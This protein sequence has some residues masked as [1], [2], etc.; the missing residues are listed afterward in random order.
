MDDP[1]NIYYDL[2]ITNIK[3]ETT[4]PV[5]IYFNEN[6]Q[7]PMLQNSGDYRLSITRFQVDTQLLPLFIPEIEMNQSDPNK[8]IYSITYK[9]LPPKTDDDDDD[10]QPIIVHQPIYWN[11]QSKNAPIPP[12][13]S[14][15]GNGLQSTVANYYYA[16]SFQ[17]VVLQVFTALQTGF[18]TLQSQTDTLNNV[19]PPIITW[20]TDQSVA[21]IS[22]P[23]QYFNNHSSYEPNLVENPNAIEL[24]FNTP[25][26]S[27]FSSFP[28]LNYGPSATAGMNY[29]IIIDDMTGFN[30][31]LLPSVPQAGQTQQTFT[32][33]FQEYSTIS[34]W[35][36]VSSICFTSNTLPI[37][38]SQLSAPLL[39]NESRQVS[40]GNNANFFQEITDLAT[41]DLCY[42]PN[43]LY[44]PS[45]QYRYISLNSNVPISNIDVQVY[46]KN[47]LGQFIPLLLASGATCTI[48]F[49]FE[50]LQ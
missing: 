20:N 3:S 44:S 9:Y 1:D 45:A 28:S 21:V 31:T 46:W 33:V 40:L 49:L 41:N 48:K 35:T 12:A 25:L 19:S 13:P 30:T 8:T 18:A 7:A 42:K 34:N 16:Y 24:Y 32:Q 27:L 5:P 2:T 50:K 47:K 26:F 38:S 43:L 39:Y 11:P 36:P 15:T 22:A 37:V 29:R 23:S 4:E 17:W 14:Q 6:R 10:I